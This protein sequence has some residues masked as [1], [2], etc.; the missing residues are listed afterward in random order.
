MTTTFFNGQGIYFPSMPW[1]N[2]GGVVIASNLVIDASAE[3]AAFCGRVWMISAGATKDIN[4]VHIILAACTTTAVNPATFRLSLQDVT[5]TGGIMVPDGT[6]DQ[7]ATAV[8]NTLTSSSINTFTLG[9]N[10]T[11]SQGDLIAVHF[12]YS[13]FTAGDVVTIGS[14]NLSY[15]AAQT[16]SELNVAG[17]YAIQNTGPMVTLEYTDGTFGT[18][19]GG[20]AAASISNPTMSVSLTGLAPERGVEFTV[21]VPMTIDGGYSILGHAASAGSTILLYNET[22][23]ITNAV[24]SINPNFYG[25]TGQRSYEWTFPAQISLDP[26]NTYRLVHRAQNSVPI[27]FQEMGVLDQSNLQALSGGVNFFATTRATV[28]S[29]FTTTSTKRGL[30]GIRAIAFSDGAG[31]SS[32]TPSSFYIGA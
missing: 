13:A 12:D 11:V 7:S 9:A 21:S 1:Y 15:F 3:K 23:T 30:M 8:T 26:G 4:K 16:L 6:A 31:G 19:E 2:A 28:G 22:T 20:Y 29:G 24:V 18:L 32:T 17:T 25:S 27:T 5:A 10:R 14:L